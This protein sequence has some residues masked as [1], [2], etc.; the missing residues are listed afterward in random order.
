MEPILFEE[1]NIKTEPNLAR[2][3]QLKSDNHEPALPVIRVADLLKK[4]CFVFTFAAIM[5]S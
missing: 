1:T 3:A 5:Q 2:D 4:V